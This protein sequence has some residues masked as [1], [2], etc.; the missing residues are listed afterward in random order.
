MVI[1]LFARKRNIKG[2]K[3]P[4]LFSKSIQLFSEVKYVGLTLDKGLTW[5]KQ[6]HEVINKVYKA[7]WACK[8]TF[9]KT[10]VLKSKV[11]YWIYTA[12]VRPIVTYATTIWWSKVKLKTCQ[13]ELSKLQRTACLGITGAM[14]RAP[15]AT[16]EVLLRFPPLHLQVEAEAKVGNYRLHCNE[17]WK[18]KSE[19]SGHTQTHTHTHMIQDMKKE[20]ILQMEYD[21]MI[22]RHVFDKSFT[23]KI[24]ER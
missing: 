1:I 3:E 9:G 2:L 14:R 19:G 13:A 22:P 21:K 23:I 4:I 5:K 8:D 10:W 15:T 11:L 17:K 18:P 24:L 6:I 12:A 16:M 20:P 7:F